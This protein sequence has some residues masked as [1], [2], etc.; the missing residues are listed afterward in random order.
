MKKREFGGMLS[1]Y[2][3]VRIFSAHA[4]RVAIETVSFTD[5]EIDFYVYKHL[6]TIF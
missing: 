1:V 3:V 2:S 5:C 6:T 4:K